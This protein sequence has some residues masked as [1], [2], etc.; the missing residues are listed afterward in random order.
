MPNHGA[1]PTLVGLCLDKVVAN[2][3]KVWCAAFL[4]AM[5]EMPDRQWLH[6]IGP[7]DELAAHLCHGLL[8]ALKAAN[9]LRKHHAYLLVNPHF[10]RLDLAAISPPPL[11]HLILKL[12]GA[13][14]QSSLQ[15]LDLSKNYNSIP[16]N[17]FATGA[18]DGLVSLSLRDCSSVGDATVSALG[19]GNARRLADLDLSN[20]AVTDRG[21]TSLVLPVDAEGAADPRYGQCRA[22]RRL[23]VDDT[24]VT[25][26]AVQTCLEHLPS[27]AWLSCANSA[28]AI[29]GILQDR[30]ESRF[31]GLRNL[32]F[33][34]G[35]T[36]DAVVAAVIAAPQVDTVVMD[37][38]DDFTADPLLALCGLESELKAVTL[39]RTE[40][41]S[42]VSAL[43]CLTPVLQVHG[44]SITKL[45]LANVCDVNVRLLLHLCP[46]LAQLCLQFNGEYTNSFPGDPSQVEGQQAGALKALELRCLDDGVASCPQSDDLVSLLSS[47][48]L[49]TVDLA[50]C[51]RLTDD[52]A[53][54]AVAQNACW[55][56]LSAFALTECGEV[57]LSPWLP[58]LLGENPLKAV[59]LINCR[60]I[61]KSDVQDY[62]RGL[63]AAGLVKRVRVNWT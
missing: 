63:D 59:D 8:A 42:Y 26:A 51:G 20:T 60:R 30:P 62:T 24:R 21:L 49:E 17:V 61:T 31:C 1:V 25:A 15:H 41:A 43:E 16:Q 52:V 6:V 38:F 32:S 10:K 18:F 46:R 53:S 56:R 39:K 45:T 29:Y 57:S 7:F 28:A 54:G 13:R 22:L 47:P 37:A 48:A 2:M 50:F 19:A 4:D 33:D 36:E 35:A 14:C 55:P 27:L 12:A 40:S 34:A 11:L 3:D 44:K 58:V 9:S 5:Q 23:D